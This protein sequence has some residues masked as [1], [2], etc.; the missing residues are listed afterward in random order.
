MVYGWCFVALEHFGLYSP[1]TIVDYCVRL[2]LMDSSPETRVKARHSI[3][4]TIKARNF[5]IEGDGMVFLDGQ[6]PIMG[7]FG[8]RFKQALPA[9]YINEV[10]LVLGEDHNPNYEGL[11]EFMSPN[12]FY[13]V[14]DILSFQLQLG[15]IMT[16]KLKNR[17]LVHFQNLAY[18]LRFPEK[19]DATI[20]RSGKET[21]PVWLG[22]RWKDA[23][24][25]ETSSDDSRYSLV[26]TN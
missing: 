1:A 6:P 12:Q 2:E 19:G 16:P 3:S 26:S 8:W 7:H 17:I 22:S 18:I 13:S 25:F 10:G 4:S 5:P 11:V 23:V 14:N 15:A 9:H 24:D 21:E 20:I